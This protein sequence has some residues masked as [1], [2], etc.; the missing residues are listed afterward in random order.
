MTL[1][2]IIIFTIMLCLLPAR[3]AFSQVDHSG[4]E[5]SG[6][7]K[8][9]HVKFSIHVPEAT[10][11]DATIF[12]AGNF[13]HERAWKANG[14]R[15]ER[16]ENGEYQGKLELVRGTRFEFKITRG[17]WAT[18]E[19]DSAGGEISN[20]VL[21]VETNEVV[22]ITVE[23]WADQV[24]SDAGKGKHS[25]AKSTLTGTIKHLPQVV[26]KF[27][28]RDR[29]VLVYLPPDYG[30]NPDRR[31]PVLYM[32]DGENVFDA[33]TSFLG[34]EWGADETAER[35]IGEGKMEP[36]IIVAISN[37]DLRMDEY[38]PTRDAHFGAGGRGGDYG[39]FMVEELKPFIDGTYG[40]LP[41]KGHTGVAGS[42][43]GG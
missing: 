21:E 16:N 30:S 28:D 24:R 23:G 17:S 15:L 2:E 3:T 27:L 20:R 1:S 11:D 22:S 31:Y 7:G 10:P 9:A 42:S 19:K 26:S 32:H 36:I 8:T 35:L 5:T 43:L 34:V 14:V 41:D 12:I 38:T 4:G 33:S 6:G 40:T 18:V 39:R 13:H 25:A 29:D 37:T